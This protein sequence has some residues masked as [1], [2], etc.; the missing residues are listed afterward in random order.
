MGVKFMVWSPKLGTPQ[1]GEPWAMEWRGDRGFRTRLRSRLSGLMA[2]SLCW[3][4]RPHLCNGNGFRHSAISFLAP[5]SQGNAPSP[6]S[7]A[8]LLVGIHS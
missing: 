3:A 4:S 1:S 5:D 7:A 8:S 6:A 2:Y